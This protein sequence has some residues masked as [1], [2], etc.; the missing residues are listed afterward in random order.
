M[1]SLTKEQTELIRRSILLKGISDPDL[2]A[3]LLDHICSAVETRMAAGEHFESAYEAAMGSF[4]ERELQ[5]VQQ[6]TAALLDGRKVFYPGIRQSLG[7]LFLFFVLYFFGR[8]FVLNPIMQLD[9]DF[10]QRHAILIESTLI[11][12]CLLLVIAYAKMELNERGFVQGPIF[13]FKAVPVGIFPPIAGILLVSGIWM[14]I[15]TRWIP[16]PDALRQVIS[17]RLTHYPPVPVFVF[18]VLLFPVLSEVLYRGIILKG[19]LRKQ[20]GPLKAILVSSLLYAFCWTPHFFGGTFLVGLFCGWL[21]YRT[22]SL[23]PSVA[24]QMAAA[25]STFAGILFFKPQTYEQ[26]AWKSIFPSDALYYGVGLV[27]LLATILLIWW[28]KNKFSRHPP[29]AVLSL[30]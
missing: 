26:M 12:G 30:E 20:H 24:V 15:A 11:S 9:V 14:E 5:Q 22:G 25:L 27:S 1:T 28:L 19:L 10:Y 21:F 16:I 8:F 4:G 23:L 29:E 13:P 3:D 17:F 2:E 6:K 7:M 18:S